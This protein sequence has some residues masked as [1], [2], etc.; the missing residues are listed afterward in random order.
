MF[1]E[2]TIEKLVSLVNRAY[3]SGY[4]AG[5]DHVREDHGKPRNYPK[6]DQFSESYVREQISM[7]TTGHSANDTQ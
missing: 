4:R 6:G 3:L 2:Q 1:D 5:S 7:I